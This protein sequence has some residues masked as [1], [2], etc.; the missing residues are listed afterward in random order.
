MVQDK[1]ETGMYIVDE[2]FTILNINDTMKELYPTVKVGDTCYKAIALQQCQCPVC[3]LMQDNALFYN[4]L[5][6]EWISANAATIQ[7]PGHGKCYTVQFHIRHNIS[8]APREDLQEDNMDEHIMELSGGSLDVCAIGSYCEPGAPLSYVNSQLLKLMGYSS[9][10]EMRV[11]VD[12]MVFNTIHPEDVEKVAADLTDCAINGG[13]FETT[14]RLHRKGEAWLWV[15]ARGKRVQ[16]ASGA[17]VLLCVITD[18]NAFL[19]RQN[20]LQQENENLLQG[21]IASQAALAS[22]PSG[23]HRCANDEGYSFLFV[24]KSFEQLVGYTA[25]QLRTELDN[26]FINLLI[27]EDISR[28]AQL[29]SALAQRGTGDIAYRIRRRD[30]Q[31]RWVQDSTMAVEWEGES[32]FQCTIADITDFVEQLEDLSRQKA[33]FDMASERIPCGYHRCTVDNGFRLE[34][35]S[36]NFLEIMGYD[37]RED[38]MN[39]PFLDFVVPEDRELFMSHEPVLASEGKVELVYRIRRK[40]GTIRW[41]KDSTMRIHYNGKDTYQCILADITEHVEGL[42]EARAQAEASNQA[43]SAFLFN[44]S[45]DIRTP[46]NAIQGFANIIQENA[47]KPAVVLDAVKK[48]KHSGD[49][50]LT[51]MNDVLELS[52]IEQGKETVNRQP[53]DMQSHVEKLYEML[54]QEMQASGI[55]FRMENSIV[56]PLVFA[57]DLKLT[58]IA[59]NFLSNARKFTPAGGC[60]TFGIAESDWDGAHATYTLFVQDTGIGMSKEFQE[61][62]FEQFERERTSTASGVTGSGLGLSITKKL[63]DL[64]G[65]TCTIESELGKGT[66]MSCSVRLNLA[67]E[68]DFQPDGVLSGEDLTGMRVLLVE[69]NDFNREIARYVFE[70]MG[71]AVEEAVNGLECLEKISAAAQGYYDFVL[72]DIQM[73]VMDGYQA[74]KEIRRNGDPSVSRIPIIAMTANA[75]DEDRKRCLAIGMDGHIAKPMDPESILKELARVVAKGGGRK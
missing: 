8:D 51:L 55:T 11:A 63:A 69:D 25:E 15:V 43:K 27:P 34:F 45:H 4:P 49:V 2:N 40:D 18:L 53:L 22:M 29:E 58:R 50:L 64:V 9:V 39:R 14:Y 36:N 7:Y 74:T 41:V 32:A 48:L 71:L 20:A 30:G 38:L 65:G 3:P 44:A 6:K 42:N 68:Q 12:G 70:E 1:F 24:S 33:Q 59:M 5:R 73:P 61:H 67:R 37:K 28:F 17:Y 54:A 56:H 21:K 62:A 35:I 19:K 72:M 47:E 52:R 31:I 13:T 16:T 10:E 23:Y 75:F 26:K 66:R 60:V 57:D 46:M